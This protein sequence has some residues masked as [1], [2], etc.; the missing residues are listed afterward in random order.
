MSHRNARLTPLGRLTIAHEHRRGR[1]PA[2]IADGMRVSRATVHKWLK[3][4]ATAGVA[5]L[6]DAPSRPLRSPRRTS[7]DLEAQIAAL[8]VESGHGPQ[9][10][11]DELAIPAST[12]YRVLCRLELNRLDVLHRTTR[13]PIRRYERSRPGELVHLDSKKLGRIPDGGGKRMQPGFAETGIGRQGRRGHGYDTLHIA[14]DDYSRVAFVEVLPDAGKESTSLFL[15][16]TLQAFQTFG[17]SVERVLTDNAL[18]YR[19]HPFRAVAATAGVQLRRT[20][21]YRPQT[22]GKA[23]RLI[24]TMLREWAYV[25][26]YA[27]NVERL[28]ALPLF[29]E[30]YNMSRPHAALAHR[31]PITRISQQRP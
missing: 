2:Q 3:R 1:T 25:R 16:H 8:R 5:A 23:E 22:N 27:S 9:R 18:A 6:E 15:H 28:G 17:V 24:Q 4:F 31:P 11:A 30:E 20:R 19:S 26:P 7:E 13:E 14:I 12:V 29:L 21:P 10:L